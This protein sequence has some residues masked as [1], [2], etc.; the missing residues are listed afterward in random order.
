MSSKLWATALAW[1]L[2]TVWKIIQ[3]T[4]ILIPLVKLSETMLTFLVVMI[5]R[6]DYVFLAGKI[7]RSAQYVVMKLPG[8]IRHPEVFA[9]CLAAVT[10]LNIPNCYFYLIGAVKTFQKIRF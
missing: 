3:N 8:K 2:E 4:I 9:K 1:Y 6:L 5:F 10:F 7:I